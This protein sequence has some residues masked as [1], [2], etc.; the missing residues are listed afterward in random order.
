[1]TSPDDLGA[2]LEAVE[3]LLH[4]HGSRIVR[5]E[6][7]IA[8]ISPKDPPPEGSA[9]QPPKNFAAM[10]LPSVRVVVTSWTKTIDEVEVHEFL[11]NPTRTLKAQVV[12]ADHRMSSRLTPGKTYE[13]AARTTRDGKYSDWTPRIRTTIA[14][15]TVAPAPP[16]STRQLPID[17]LPELRNFTIMLPT[18]NQ[19]DPDNEYA[20]KW[21][22]IPNV[23]F[24][25]D[26]GVVFRANA[27]GFHSKGSHFPRAEARQMADDK[28]TKGLW[29]STGPKSIEC[30]LSLDTSK[31]VK[32]KRL[33]GMQIHAGTDDVCQIMLHETNGLGFIHNDGKSWVPID[34]DYKNG[35]R[36]TCKIE[37]SDNH[38]RVAYNGEKKVDVPKT[39]LTWFWKVG[40]Y[41]QTNVEDYKEDPDATGEVVV[42]RLTT[43]GGGL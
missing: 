12:G 15:D 22:V 37:V 3:A 38:I 43:T 29:A 21:G 14:A 26:G 33:N 13:W 39:G 42:Y 19:G 7:A 30:E 8:A 32:R 27:G 23:L 24:V 34:P 1:M 25:R 36:F 18:G 16:A 40:A 9:L 11:S 4:D 6:E 20:V 31:L 41:L 2:R 17:V 28:G 10:E 35:T 5:N